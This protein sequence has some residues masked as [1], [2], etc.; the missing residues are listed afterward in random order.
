MNL[1]SILDAG[2]RGAQC[3]I[4][5]VW[6]VPLLGAR[7]RSGDDPGWMSGIPVLLGLLMILMSKRFWKGKK[8]HYLHGRPAYRESKAYMA[9]GM[10]FGLSF[11]LF[12]IVWF[13]DE[14]LAWP[15]MYPTLLDVLAG[16]MAVTA[17]AAILYIA[18][19]V[20]V[21]VPNR[22]RPPYQRDI[23]WRLLHEFGVDADEVPDRTVI[24]QHAVPFD[25]GPTFQFTIPS[26][27]IR[28]DESP[29]VV[30]MPESWDM[31]TIMAIALVEIEP[32]ARVEDYFI[33]ELRAMADQDDASLV[34]AWYDP[35][36]RIVEVEIDQ[37]KSSFTTWRRHVIRRDGWALLVRVTLPGIRRRRDEPEVLAAVRSVRFA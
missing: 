14:Y 6:Q 32:N 15:S 27:W 17:A 1:S 7:T 8:D 34:D 25:R 36:E 19:Y 16:A 10:P 31:T 21:G 30:A 23:R 5:P 4:D 13:S 3:W 33:E 35:D 9:A 2:V 28:S 11:I 22:L 29:V 18:I 12:G 24:R 20:I 26:G 37:A